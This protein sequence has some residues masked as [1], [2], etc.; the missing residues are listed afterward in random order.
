ML[1]IQCFYERQLPFKYNTIIL[2][3]KD[4]LILYNN[5]VNVK[6]KHNSNKILINQ[7]QLISV[8]QTVLVLVLLLDSFFW[9]ETNVCCIRLDVN[10]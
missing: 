6:T 1:F 2:P 9:H 7:I 10:V 3:K 5:V 8:F 4:N